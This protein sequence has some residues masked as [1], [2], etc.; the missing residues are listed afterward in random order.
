MGLLSWKQYAERVND[1]G[2]VEASR[3]Y[4][5]AVSESNNL[6]KLVDAADSRAYDAWERR[7]EA[8]ESYYKTLQD[9]I[10]VA[11]AC[12]CGCEKS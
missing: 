12:K 1:P 2:Y 3:L 5:D 11:P 7:E 8:K 6:A 9:E 4:D 10:S